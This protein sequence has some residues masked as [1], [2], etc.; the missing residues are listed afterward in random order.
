MKDKI[1]SNIKQFFPSSKQFLVNGI[2]RIFQRAEAN[3]EYKYFNQENFTFI[4]CPGCIM[5]ILTTLDGVTQLVGA[6]S[7]N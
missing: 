4:V 3:S 1:I 2:L 5:K 6:S 7:S